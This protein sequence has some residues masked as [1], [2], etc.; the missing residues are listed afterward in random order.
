MLKKKKKK[1]RK[2]IILELF[3]ILAFISIL[4]LI[5]NI[6]GFSG[7]ITENGSFETTLLVVKNIL[8]KDGIKYIL[9]NSLKNF[10]NLEPVVMI[11][12]SLI[13]I[14]ILEAS[15][16]LKHIFTPMKKIKPIF[17]TMIVM[18][19]GIISTFVGDY[20][21][22]LLLPLAG[23]MYKYIGRNSSLGI[24]TMFLAITAGYGTGIIYNYQVYELGNITE[25]A[26]GTIVT[27]YNYE[28]L[29]NIFVLITSTILFTI[30]GSIIVEKF[31]KKYN[32]NEETDN[33]TISKK[34]GFCTLI[35]FIIL[36]V[37][38]VYSIIPGLPHSGLLLAKGE[39]TYIGKLFSSKSPL[40]QGFMFLIII[41]LMVCGF[42]Y[43]F[44]SRNIKNTADYT[45]ALTKSYE[46]TG[47]VFV[48]MFFVSIIYLF[49]DWT[50]ISTILA[51]NI[52]DFV[53]AS[54]LSGLILVIVAFLSIVIISIFIPSSVTKWNLIAPVYVPLLMRANI[55][56]TFTQ[57]LFLAADSVGKM[58]SPIYIYLIVA[59]GFMHK[60][61][62]DDN[63]N[64]FGTMKKLMPLIVLLSVI[65]IIIIFGWYLLGIP[66][67]INT[68]ITL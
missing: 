61:D 55:S 34:A 41:I 21:Y 54:R 48:L 49:L 22:A 24:A 19:V 40:N 2:G 11:I 52:I 33:L 59:I 30:V 62:K 15:G 66:T 38:F 46:G 5:L 28:L 26:A 65:W 14:S 58:F 50:K 12:L 10:Q 36:T 7:Y 27:G 1:S 29:S 32:R 16:L 63:R 3:I 35:V 56:P 67:G 25:V 68:N 44:V 17:V 6:V 43:G 31:S 20:S 8:S 37:L 18:F 42:V 13:S 23:I 47:Y 53:G 4:S 51:T 45:K 60:Y 64:I 57:T 39:P 9:N